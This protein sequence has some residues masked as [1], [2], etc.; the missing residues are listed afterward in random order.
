M[1]KRAWSLNYFES[2]SR[3]IATSPRICPLSA[4]TSNSAESYDRST[5]Y[6]EIEAICEK[7]KG[8]GGG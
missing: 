2:Q 7:R 4:A 6:F 5:L 1:L 3:Y 8:L